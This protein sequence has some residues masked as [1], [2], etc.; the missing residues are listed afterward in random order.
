MHEKLTSDEF[1][2]GIGNGVGYS[3][4]LIFVALFRELLAQVSL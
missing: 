2:D 4:V 1:F 3:L